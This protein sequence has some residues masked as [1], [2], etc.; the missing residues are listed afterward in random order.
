MAAAATGVTLVE[1]MTVSLQVHF[2]T[3]SV[4]SISENGGL[5]PI[6]FLRLARQP[7][8]KD[9]A[10]NREEDKQDNK[11]LLG[12]VVDR[13]RLLLDGR[14]AD[15]TAGVAVRHPLTAVGADDFS[16]GEDLVE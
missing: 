11:T 8:G 16:H 3:H 14:A 12:S 13:L 4:S 2:V 10:E 7:Q 5:P 15:R 9:K 1:K 6:T